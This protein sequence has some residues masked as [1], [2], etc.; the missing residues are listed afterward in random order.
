MSTFADRRSAVIRGLGGLLATAGGGASGVATADAEARPNGFDLA[1]ALVPADEIL[2]GGPPRDGIPAL[3]DPRFVRPRDA[4]LAA[5]DRVLG[6]RHRG[7]TRAYPIRILNWHEIVNDR[8]GGDPVAVTYCPLCGTGIAFAAMLRGNPVRFG[9]SGLLYRSDMLMY[10][11]GSESLWSQIQGRAVTGP[12]RGETLQPLV[13]EHTTWRDWRSRYPHTE[14]LSFDTGFAR[15]YDRDPYAGYERTWELLFPA[16]PQD[17][18]L[19]AKAWVLGVRVATGAKAYPFDVLRREPATFV[20]SIGG[21]RVTIRHEPAH[22][23]ARV[24]DAQG[25]E[26]PSVSAFWFA[27]YAFHP[28]TELHRRPGV[29][30][31]P[32]R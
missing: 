24:F 27:W 13:L 29:R 23:Q 30:A 1:G 19:D 14:V 4:R 16:G 18:R 12:R 31:A 20:D 21:Q 8:L 28:N 10:D 7:V 32:V 6:L 15:D 5:G 25:R 11:T 9:V 22:R 2:R 17:F 26:I 3:N